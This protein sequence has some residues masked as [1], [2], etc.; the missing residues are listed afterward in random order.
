[1]ILTGENKRKAYRDSG[2]WG[3]KTLADMFEANAIAHPDR[4]ALVDAP[5]RADFAFGQPRRLTYSALQAEVERYAGALVAA[6][7][8][9]DDVIVIQ[10]PNISEFV[11]LY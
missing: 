8:G 5:N 1:M 6:G 9:K 7:I 2:W 3:D 4:V 11:S 10:L